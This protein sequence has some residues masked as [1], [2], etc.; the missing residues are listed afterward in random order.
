MKTKG[1]RG[2]ALVAIACAAGS[3]GAQQ[4]FDCLIEPSQVVEVRT[5]VEGVIAS[6]GVSRGDVIRRGQPLVVLQS[7]AEKAGVDSA[8]ARAKA[9][10]AIAAA[11]NRIDY[12]TRKLARL[13]DLQREN[14]TSPQARDEA[15]AEKRLAE[16]EL[17]SALES[18]EIAR[19][20]LRRAQELLAL[21]T[22]TAPFNGVVVDRML[23]PGDLAEA[24]SGRKPV[25]K[26][27]QIDPLRVDVVLPAS[28]WGQ[29]RIGAK[30]RVTALVGGGQHEAAVRAVDR[31]I[32]AAS[33]TFVA[34]LEL[35]NPRGAVPGGSRCSAAIEGVSPPARGGPARPR[36]D[37]Q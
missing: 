29:V 1:V 30:A 17:Q 14:F 34:R 2:L 24:G 18:R 10:G 23:N 13:T 8:A 9:E 33:G 31:V 32:D 25:L 3:A 4:A 15:D 12:A 26:V 35:P 36:A 11:R 7:E 6:I 37:G 5:P 28:L 20:E 19:L 22:I 21:R 27:A 16:A